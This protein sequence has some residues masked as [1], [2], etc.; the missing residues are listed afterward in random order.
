M[1]VAEGRTHE[2]KTGSAVQSTAQ[3]ERVVKCDRDVKSHGKWYRHLTE[4]ERGRGIG[5]GDRWKFS[6][7]DERH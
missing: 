7:I 6:R 4:R 2:L 3:K 5:R 1:R